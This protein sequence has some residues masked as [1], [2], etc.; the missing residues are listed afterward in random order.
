VLSGAPLDPER[1]RDLD[2]SPIEIRVLHDC[3]L[4]PGVVDELVERLMHEGIGVVRAVD[5]DGQEIL[6]AY[7]RRAIGRAHIT[8]GERDSQGRDRAGVVFGDW[9]LPGE[10]L[11]IRSEL[12]G[13]VS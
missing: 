13:D 5:G 2:A 9:S 3:A 10:M 4:G 12:D 11:G 1:R 7:R 8:G 6:T